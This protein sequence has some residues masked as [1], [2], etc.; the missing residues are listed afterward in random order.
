MNVKLNIGCGDKQESGFLN[1]DIRLD[2]KPDVVADVRKLPFRNG[3]V[4]VILASHVIEHFSHRQTD[5]ILRD[6]ID[7][8]QPGGVL[9]IACPDIEVIFRNYGLVYFDE[10]IQQIFGDQDYP[11]NYHYTG[12][13]KEV[14]AE[15][16]TALRM[17]VVSMQ[18]KHGQ[19]GIWAEKRQ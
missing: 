10:W 13:T 4:A 12:F 16:L 17:K 8:L 11:F 14:L 2:V 19:I 9:Q 6:W 3:S 18:S 15:K 5:W 7:L 1:I